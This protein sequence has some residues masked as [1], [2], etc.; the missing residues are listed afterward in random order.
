MQSIYEQELGAEFA[1]LHPRIQERLQLHSTQE[2][3]FI[4]RGV[5]ERVWHGPVYTQPFLRVGLLRNIMFPEAGHNIPFRIENY[6]YRDKLGR[7]T[8][9]WIR[10]FEFARRTRC[11]DATMVRSQRRNCIVDYL[12]THQH[13]AVDIAL[14]VTPRGG[15]RL[16]SGAQRFH[17]GPFSF[18]FPMLLSGLADVEEWYDDAAGCYRIQVEVSNP[19]FG[20]IFGYHGSFQPEWQ[21]VTAAQIPT[22]ALP[23]R[24]ESRE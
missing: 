20:K 22:Y 10:R 18:Q 23:V 11:F 3:A 24:L 19:T 15:L 13:L 21:P 6:A 1:R 2:R 14:A 7:E 17:E 12:G 16:R 4:G 8:V 5:M 9:T